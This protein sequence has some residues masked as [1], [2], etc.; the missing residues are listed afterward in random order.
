MSLGLFDELKN[1]KI[2]LKFEFLRADDN[3]QLRLKFFSKQQLKLILVLK[4]CLTGWT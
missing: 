3:T 1:R 4:R 2:Q